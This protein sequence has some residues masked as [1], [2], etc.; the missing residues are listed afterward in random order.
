MEIAAGAPRN[1]GRDAAD[2]AASSRPGDPGKVNPPFSVAALVAPAL[3]PAWLA[4]YS[5]GSM[6]TG[7]GFDEAWAYTEGIHEI[8]LF[9]GRMDAPSG[10]AVT[11]AT[12]IIDDESHQLNTLESEL[13]SERH[14]LAGSA[15]AAPAA[16]SSPSAESL[17]VGG[18]VVPAGV[19]RSGELW[20]AR[21]ELEVPEPGSRGNRLIVTVVARGVPFEA[22]ALDWVDDLRPFVAERRRMIDV[23][24]NEGPASRR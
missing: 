14:R 24:R 4:R 11:V 9:F 19:C 12:T 1:T 8:S 3:T 16:S 18:A 13:A 10:P 20:A 22:T 5:W 7:V 23:I 2:P 21:T 15:T 17:R 6:T